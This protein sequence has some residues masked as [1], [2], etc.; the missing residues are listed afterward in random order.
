ML[1]FINNNV[2]VEGWAQKNMLTPPEK[3][4][5]LV[6]LADKNSSTVPLKL[7]HHGPRNN[8]TLLWALEFP[9]YQILLSYP[10]PNLPLLPTIR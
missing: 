2:I 3:L 1:T 6:Y 8:P 7:H 9:G 4:P 10:L 5:S